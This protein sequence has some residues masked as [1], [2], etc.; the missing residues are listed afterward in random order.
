MLRIDSS[1]PTWQAV[2]SAPDVYGPAV[3]AV[4]EGAGGGSALPQRHF[5]GV[6]DQVDAQVLGHPPADHPA[7]GNISTTAR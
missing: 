5:Q 2:P 1:K 6:D 3:V 4:M 7:G